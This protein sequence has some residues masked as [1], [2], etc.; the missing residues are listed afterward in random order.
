MK[1]FSLQL[2]F[3]LQA[4]EARIEYKKGMS[5]RYHGRTMLDY[6]CMFFVLGL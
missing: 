3:S 1:A 2:S 4:N 6:F 5:T